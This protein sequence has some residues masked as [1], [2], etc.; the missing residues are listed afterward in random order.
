MKYSCNYNKLCSFQYR[1]MLSRSF[2]R[3]IRRRNSAKL[4]RPV[5]NKPPEG[6]QHQVIH[7]GPRKQTLTSGDSQSDSLTKSAEEPHNIC[8][9]RHLRTSST[10]TVR[11]NREHQ[12]LAVIMNKANES[13]HV[14]LPLTPY[15]LRE[16][17]RTRRSSWYSKAPVSL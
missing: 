4:G 13:A 1:I 9:N 11:T 5:L 12:P 3:F 6:P 7:F 17:R 10:V 15:L 2:S 16:T 14:A 8:N